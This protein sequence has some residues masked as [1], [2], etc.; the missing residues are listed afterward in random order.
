MTKLTLAGCV[1][2]NDRG[3][4]LLLHR[5]G[6]REQWEL[7]GGKV[8]EGEEPAVAAARELKEE[9]GLE[10]N[11]IRELGQHDFSEDAWL[12]R[13]IWFLAKI[14]AGTPTLGEPDKFDDIAYFSWAKLEARSAELS[15][16]TR[17]LLGAYHAKEINLDEAG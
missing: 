1:L 6:Q 15:P 7:P 3:E 2:F 9:T 5:Y 4:L 12:M 16:N 10:V 13:Y 11:I 8:E 14:T 17:N